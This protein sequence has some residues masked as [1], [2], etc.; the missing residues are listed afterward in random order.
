MPKLVQPEK[1]SLDNYNFTCTWNGTNL[2]LNI[3]IEWND[4]AASESGYYIYR[5]SQQIADLA[6]NSGNYADLYVVD[7][8]V[9]VTYAIEAYNNF[10]RSEQIIFTVSCD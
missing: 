2:D 5:N 7:G 6:P 10:G 9:S 3:T 1:P 8:G 4:K